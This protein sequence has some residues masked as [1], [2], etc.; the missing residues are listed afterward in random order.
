MVHRW[1]WCKKW[2][3][4]RQ[5]WQQSFEKCNALPDVTQSYTLVNEDSQEVEWRKKLWAVPT[6]GKSGLA[7]GHKPDVGSQG[8]VCLD[9]SARPADLPRFRTASWGVVDLRGED[10]DSG[11][12]MGRPQT[13][14]RAEL[15]G[16]A[17]AIRKFEQL[18]AW[19]DS[20]YVVKMFRK[21]CWA[22][23]S[24]HDHW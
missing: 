2:S 16:L 15:G 24:R 21:L 7:P 3:K 19:S 8:E 4:L 22:A 9:G 11:Q 10:L 5:P 18:V 17:A 14:N 1:R 13:I 23:G 6:A 20:S 12:S